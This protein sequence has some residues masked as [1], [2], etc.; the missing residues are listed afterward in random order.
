MHTVR[1]M[2]KDQVTL[3]KADGRTFPNIR[4]SVHADFINLLDDGELPV[5]EGDLVLRQLPSGLKEEYSIL[6]TIYHSGTDIFPSKYKCSV[7]KLGSKRSQASGTSDREF[8]LRAIDLARQCTSE[9]GKVSPKVGA[10]IARDGRSLG[11]AFRGEVAPGEHAEY[12]LLEKKLPSESLAGATLFTTLEPCTSR[13]PPKIACADRIIERRIKKVV[14]GTLDPN[15]RIRGRGEF[16]LRDA[17][18]EIGR[19]D[20]DLM[21]SI[22]ELNRDFMREHPVG[23]KPKRTKAQTSDPPRETG[24]NGH[25]I[26]YTKEGDK[27]E[28][29]PDEENPG[30]DWPLLLRRNDKAILEAHGEFWEKVWWNRHQIWLEKIESGEEPLTEEQKPLLRKAR[31]VAKRIEA[32]YGRENLGWDDFEWG[33]LSGQLS[34]LSW[35]IGAEWEGSLDT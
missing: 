26:G 15:D 34:A 6:E 29:V 31:E 10:V 16:R 4:A 32:K 5:E 23:Q 3:V 17:G 20:P 12:T 25:R 11:E 13:N 19:F 28:W 33:L 9:P 30:Q 2:Y 22:E 21:A 8:M 1:A 24:P 18:I 35:V 14:I 7:R 27:V